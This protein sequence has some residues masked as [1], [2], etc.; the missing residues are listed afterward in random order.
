MIG[1]ALLSAFLLSSEVSPGLS[2]REGVTLLGSEGPAVSFA[3][4]PGNSA[5]WGAGIDRVKERT[6]A[7]PVPTS[8]EDEADGNAAE[9][10]SLQEAA[11]PRTEERDK[12]K[13]KTLAWSGVSVLLTIVL[14]VIVHELIVFPRAVALQKEAGEKNGFPVID[15]ETAYNTVLE[16]DRLS[17]VSTLST[18]LLFLALLANFVYQLTRLVIDKAKLGKLF[19][20]SRAGKEGVLQG[21][22]LSS[23]KLNELIKEKRKTPKR[24]RPV[25]KPQ[26]KGVGRKGRARE[27]SAWP[28]EGTRR[29]VA[30]LL[31][32]KQSP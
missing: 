26:M 21:G 7:A 10:E 11:I 1:L 32:E 13:M 23:Q 6:P 24:R 31:T 12:S 5:R 28:E 15:D 18:G 25:R 3:R 16:H 8:L 14:S 17:S 20:R 30:L 19:R 27:H 2:S 22:S 29:G 4:R 9:L